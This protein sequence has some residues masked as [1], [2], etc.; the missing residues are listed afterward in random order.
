MDR[1]G[2]RKAVIFGHSFGG[3]VAA[4]FA[5]TEPRKTAGLVLASAVSHPWPGGA[6]SWYY[7]LTAKPVIGWVFSETL[8]LPAGWLRMKNAVACVFSPNKVPDGYLKNAAI[9]LVLRPLAFRYN[10]IDVAGLYDFVSAFSKRYRKITAPTVVISG[11]HDTVVYEEIHSAGLA[12]DI[13]GADIVWVN[14]LG[15]KS[16]YVTPELIVAAVEKVSGQDVSLQKFATA[17]ERRIA[18]DRFGPVENCLDEKLA[19]T[20]AE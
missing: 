2:I 11:T 19:G 4:A 18:G 17:A 8:S 6:T 20:E 15:H 14:N 16:D 7:E 1:L 9:P 13:R 3:V 12:R 5:V 10:A